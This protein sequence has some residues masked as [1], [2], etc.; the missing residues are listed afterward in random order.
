MKARRAERGFLFLGCRFHDQMLRTY[1]RQ[2]MKRSAGPHYAVASAS[3]LTRNEAKF[4]TD[5]AI[6][7]IDAPLADAAAAIIG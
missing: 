4:L 3:A 2:I 5:Q 1:A 7:L 6:E